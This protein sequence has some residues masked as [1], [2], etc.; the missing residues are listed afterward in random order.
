MKLIYKNGLLF[1]SIILK[2]FGKTVIIDNVVIDT[3]ASSCIFEPSALE[4]LEV[5]FT[6][7]DEIE[8]F[9]GVN[10]MYNYIKRTAESITIDDVS[11][12]KFNFYIG[13]VEDNIN[14]LIGLDLLVNMNTI[15]NLKEMEI[16]FE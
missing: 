10:G 11:V 15:I 12:N 7:D 13:S 6:K 2:Y 14:G 3:G 5:V 1:T 4:S 8:T 9:F 16:Q